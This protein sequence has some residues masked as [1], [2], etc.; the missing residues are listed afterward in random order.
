MRTIDNIFVLNY[1][2]IRNLTM[3]KGRLV[4]TF[5]NFKAAFPLVNRKAFYVRC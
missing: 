3:D 1:L 5:V 2:V 4:T